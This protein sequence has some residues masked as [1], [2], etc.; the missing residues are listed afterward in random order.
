MLL[1][2]HYLKYQITGYLPI[3]YF[4]LGLRSIKHSMTNFVWIRA[5]WNWKKIWSCNSKKTGQT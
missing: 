5:N 4:F 2:M 3:S 1:E